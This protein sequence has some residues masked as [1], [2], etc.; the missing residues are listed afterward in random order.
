MDT[1][2]LYSGT[3]RAAWG[4]F[5]LF[6]HINLGTLDLLPNFV[7]WLLLLWAIQLLGEEQR[8]LALLRP[9]GIGL[10]LYAFVDWLTVLLGATLK[11]PLL[12]ILSSI[13][14]LYFLFQLLTDCAALASRYQM[15]GDDLD[16]RILKWRNRQTVLSTLGFSLLY[17][18]VEGVDWWETLL[19]C[20]AV[21]TLCAT[22]MSMFTLFALRKL[23][24]ESELADQS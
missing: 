7:G 10:S 13:A 8:D 23:F 15:E 12:D 3:S 22:L 14:Q 16:A 19:A 20:L 6:F 17:L 4:M 1:E 2:K 9:L 11:L 5:F 21:L 24:S 18:P